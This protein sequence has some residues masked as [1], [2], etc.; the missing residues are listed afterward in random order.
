MCCIEV[1]G[2]ETEILAGLS[3]VT[4]PKTGSKSDMTIT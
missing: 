4:S 3:H 2:D 1:S